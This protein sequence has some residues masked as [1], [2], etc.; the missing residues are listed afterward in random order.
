METQL[1]QPASHWLKRSVVWRRD[2]ADQGSFQN[3]MAWM[4]MS[5]ML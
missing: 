3:L 4:H 2:M 1:F 5:M